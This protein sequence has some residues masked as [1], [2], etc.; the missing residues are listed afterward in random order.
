MVQAVTGYLMSALTNGFDQARIVLSYVC[1]D[2]ECCSYIELI[3]QVQGPA[4]WL[5]EIVISVLPSVKEVINIPVYGKAGSANRRDVIPVLYIHCD[6]Q[7]I[8][9]TPTFRAGML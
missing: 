4:C 2:K 7:I 6:D 8:C 5:C 9:H 1:N 3:Q